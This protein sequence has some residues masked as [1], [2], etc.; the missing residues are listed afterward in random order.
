MLRQGGDVFGAEGMFRFPSFLERGDQLVSVH[1]DAAF[2]QTL[3]ALSGLGC[4]VPTT[5][6]FGISGGIAYASTPAFRRRDP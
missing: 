2:S 4:A 5:Q 6:L 3:N 1:R